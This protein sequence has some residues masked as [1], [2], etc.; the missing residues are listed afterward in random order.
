MRVQNACD[1][2]IFALDFIIQEGSSLDTVFWHG[3]FIA[4]VT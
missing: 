4:C 3:E 2:Q 1:G